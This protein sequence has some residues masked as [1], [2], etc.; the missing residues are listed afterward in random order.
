MGLIAFAGLSAKPL[1]EA[2]FDLFLHVSFFHRHILPFLHL[3][4]LRILVIAELLAYTLRHVRYA[5]LQYL[6]Q[7]ISTSCNSYTTG[8]PTKRTC[9]PTTIC[10]NLRSILR[11]TAIYELEQMD[12]HEGADK[13]M[14]RFSALTCVV[15]ELND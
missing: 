15:L 8:S 7:A 13:G 6:L 3:E 14:V 4:R 12:G 1:S 10:R 2:K 11:R 5:S 9:Y